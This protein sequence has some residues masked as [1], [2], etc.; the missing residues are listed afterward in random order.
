MGIVLTNGPVGAADIDLLSPLIIH[1]AT[2]AT[3]SG[4]HNNKLVLTL[5]CAYPS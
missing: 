3:A 2:T 5:N 4:L 1:Q